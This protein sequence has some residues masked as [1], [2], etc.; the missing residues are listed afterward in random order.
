MLNQVSKSGLQT[1]A[2]DASVSCWCDPNSIEQYLT[3]KAGTATAGTLT[4]TAVP[5]DV[6]AAETVYYNGSALTQNLATV[7][8]M[9][10]RIKGTFDSINI[11][12]S[13]SN[14]TYQYSLRG[15]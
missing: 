6:G 8:Q 3:L 7:P 9:T 13:G 15:A 12:C 1:V 5:A 14:G 10:Y 2:S 11:A 4:V